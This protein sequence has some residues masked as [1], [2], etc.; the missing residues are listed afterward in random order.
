MKGLGDKD[1]LMDRAGPLEL[2]ANDFQMNL[3]ADVIDR[4]KIRGEQPVIR[5]NLEL[6]KKVRATMTESG[7][8]MPEHLPIEAPI[9]EVK[10]KI[11]G[12]KKL[13]RPKR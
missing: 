7:A 3:A 1:Q 5:K 12:Q 9:S 13:G 10:K 2:S 8:T 4:E 6:A 11:A